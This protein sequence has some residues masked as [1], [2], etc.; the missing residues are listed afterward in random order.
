ENKVQSRPN[1]SAPAAGHDGG[2]DRRQGYLHLLQPQGQLVPVHTHQHAPQA[3]GRS[4]ARSLPIRAAEEH[5]NAHRQRTPDQGRLCRGHG[6][7]RYHGAEEAQASRH[8][9]AISVPGVYE[10]PNKYHDPQI[11]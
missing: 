11:L 1:S 9:G 6:G 4:C 8:K 10:Q 7:R 3:G 5:E 2:H